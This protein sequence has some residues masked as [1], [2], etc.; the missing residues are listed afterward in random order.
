[1]LSM[2]FSELHNAAAKA[3]AAFPDSPLPDLAEGI[4]AAFRRDDTG[5]QAALERVRPI[6]G[7][8]A[9]A[10]Y[11]TSLDVISTGMRALAW[12]EL[13][14]T[15]DAGVLTQLASVLTDFI[16]AILRLQSSSDQPILRNGLVHQPFLAD[17][18]G[19]MPEWLVTLSL[20]NKKSA[21]AIMSDIVAANPCDLFEFWAGLTQRLAG[22]HVQA[23][24]F[25]AK[26]LDEEP[27]SA[28][29]DIA[30]H[31]LLLET[32]L[33]LLTRQRIPGRSV[34]DA[35]FSLL[36]CDE[37]PVVVVSRY[38]D[39]ASVGGAHSAARQFV[40][41]WRELDP[42]ATDPLLES[43]RIERRAGATQ[44]ALGLVEEALRRDPAS[45]EAA[46]LLAEL[47]ADVRTLAGQLEGSSDKP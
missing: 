45:G 24:A 40:A 25:L 30:R 22:D 31:V 39:I 16:P 19:R 43:A 34:E 8:A 42:E 26:A 32:R 33:E 47:Q 10:E 27:L 46:S 7:A 11:A 12:R 37:L 38:A 18:Y 20:G 23:E 4:A 44:A 3:R 5:I 35:M 13:Y 29:F 14:D 15:Q 17:S 9:V 36:R 21:A 28:E 1:M 41:R 2:N 6:M